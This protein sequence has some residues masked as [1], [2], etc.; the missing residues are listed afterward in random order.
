[1]AALATPPLMH[2][3][4]HWLAFHQ[5][6]SGG[7]VVML[8][9]GRF[10]AV[11]AWEAIS[12]EKVLTLVIIGDAMAKPLLDELEANPERYDFSTFWV[13]ASSG[14]GLSQHNKDR[15]ARL[16]PGRM[17]LDSFGSSE[18]GVLGSKGGQGGATFQVNEYTAVLDDANTKVEPGSERVGK[19][20][21]RGHV[22]L[23]YHNDPEKT[24]K[25]F[26]E[27]DGER[28]AITGDDATVESDGT[29]RILGR[30]SQCINTGGEKVYPEEVEAVLKA[31]PAVY[32]A[33]VA[34]VPDERF[35]QRVAALVQLR[36]D[37]TAPTEDELIAHCRA[38]VAGY[39]APRMVVVVP[40]IRRSPSGKA[41][42]P[43]AARIAADAH[44]SA[45]TTG[46]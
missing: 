17:V 35:G 13:I 22:P 6:F 40:E 26:V 20:A 27:V 9:Q 5:L 15:F 4:A 14:A 1:L 28:W 2:A 34:G 37:A 46:G 25:T 18:T 3:S 42:Y 24:A 44:H 39:K 8:P 41:D 7:K 31:H 29:I 23:R 10:D 43:W 12:N 38:H 32:D 19:V 11:A 30:G 16:L 21:R 33:V 36:P 45:A